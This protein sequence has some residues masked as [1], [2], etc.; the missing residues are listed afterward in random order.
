M[1]ATRRAR[2]Q[3]LILEELSVRISRKIKDPRVPSL[4]LTRV[5]LTQDAGQATVYF[6][7][8][9]ETPSEDP[10]Y[11]KRVDDCQEG[12]NSAIGFLRR[13]IGKVLT[14]RQ[15]PTLVFKEDRGLANTLRVHEL[16]KQLEGEK[17]DNKT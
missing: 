16:L 5:E 8:L 6:T 3:Q 9:G 12:L 13:E 10:D 2:L 1:D 11:R 15:M 17:R 7:L 4:T 14:V